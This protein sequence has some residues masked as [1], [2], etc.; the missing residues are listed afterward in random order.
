MPRI[1]YNS[2]R[3]REGGSHFDSDN[4]K[5]LEMSGGIDDRIRITWKKAV[6]I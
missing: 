3:I 6:S 1:Q 4:Q 2:P 5:S